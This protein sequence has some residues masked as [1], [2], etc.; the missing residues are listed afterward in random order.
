MRTYEKQHPK[1]L[2]EAEQAQRDQIIKWASMDAS[3]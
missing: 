3:A 1:E 2:D